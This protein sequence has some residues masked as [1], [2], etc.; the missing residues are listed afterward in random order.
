MLGIKVTIERFT[1]DAQPGWVEC[2]LIDAAGTPHLFEEKVPVV[3]SDHLDANSGYP[4]AGIIGCTVV[5]ARLADDGRELVTVDTEVPWGIESTAGKARF[6]IF[7]EQMVE[8]S[9]DAE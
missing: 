5:R 7:R 1:E 6:D 8:F 3:T 2:R 4:Q 9:H